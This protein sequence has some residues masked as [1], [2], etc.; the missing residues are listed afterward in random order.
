MNDFQKKALLK[1]D[2]MYVYLQTVLF[3]IDLL[4]VMS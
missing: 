2:P 1:P 3:L 4:D